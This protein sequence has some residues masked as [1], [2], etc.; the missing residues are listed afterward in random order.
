[1]NAIGS[2]FVVVVL[3]LD[4]AGATERK[5]RRGGDGGGRGE[6]KEE[7]RRGEERHLT[8]MCVGSV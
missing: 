5:K 8:C 6:R 2:R 7:E 4:N 3:P 1:M